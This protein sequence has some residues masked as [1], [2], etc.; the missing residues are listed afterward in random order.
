MIDIQLSDD[1]DIV[2]E[3]TGDVALTGRFTIETDTDS[4]RA[5][6]QLALMAIKTERG[7]FML[8]P[9]LG[10]DINKLHGFPNSP[11]VANKGV[12]LIQEAIKSFGITS[13]VTINSWP[14]DM[15]TIAYEVNI[16]V[17]SQANMVTFTIKQALDSIPDYGV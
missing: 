9:S 14:V 17:G 1:G 12:A 6:S 8:H 15:S 11:A 10:C 13:S 7:D 16:Q 5:I 2:V 3:P 4:A